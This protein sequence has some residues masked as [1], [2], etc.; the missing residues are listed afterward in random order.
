MIHALVIDL[1]A[2][3]V[4]VRATESGEPFRGDFDFGIIVRERY[5]PRG[6]SLPDR[7]EPDDPE[8]VEKFRQYVLTRLPDYRAGTTAGGAARPATRNAVCRQWR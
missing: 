6:E 4:G 5:G 2:P 1:C 3:G 8:F 7:P